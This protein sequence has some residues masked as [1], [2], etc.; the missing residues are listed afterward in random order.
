MG[1]EEEIL[2]QQCQR[3]GELTLGRLRPRGDEEANAAAAAAAG[4]AAM[5]GPME[6]Y[7]L[8]VLA[9]LR[10]LRR[11]I[12]ATNSLLVHHDTFLRSAKQAKVQRGKKKAGVD[13]LSIFEADDRFRVTHVQGG[14]PPWL[15]AADQELV[16]GG[17][18]ASSGRKQEAA[19]EGRAGGGAGDKS[20]KGGF[21][22]EEH[23]D[24]AEI[25]HDDL[26][27]WG[28]SLGPLGSLN[29]QHRRT[30]ELAM[31]AHGGGENNSS[32]GASFYR[33]EPED[34]G[35]VEEALQ[36]GRTRRRAPRRYW[37]E[38][39]D[40]CRCEPLHFKVPALSAN[41]QRA[42]THIA[43]WGGFVA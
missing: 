25:I 24:G 38:E 12:Q 39:E 41:P 23:R 4:E 2:S 36:R 33:E 3:M 35:A 26:D 1:R 17:P 40:T 7:R 30:L 21:D 29:S 13:L 43:S 27:E 14:G 28:D 9:Y 18:G 11:A 15:S 5:E 19:G 42:K 37:E 20:E 8:M 22:G 6:R 32:H 31:G 34:A 16:A 10:V